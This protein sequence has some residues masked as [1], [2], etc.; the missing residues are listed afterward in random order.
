MLVLRH[1]N[2]T[3]VAVI[4]GQEG[5]GGQ[6]GILDFHGNSLRVVG[7]AVILHDLD[8]HGCEALCHSLDGAAFVDGHDIL[9]AGFKCNGRVTG[10]VGIQC[11]AKLY[12]FGRIQGQVVVALKETHIAGVADLLL[13]AVDDVVGLQGL[14]AIQ[15]K[16]ICDGLVVAHVTLVAFLQD[17]NLEGLAV[18][19]FGV[20]DLD[21]RIAGCAGNQ[22]VVDHAHH[23]GTGGSELQQ[24]CP[25]GFGVDQ[26]TQAEYLVGAHGQALFQTVIDEG[27]D[28][29]GQVD[30]VG[31]VVQCVVI[32]RQNEGVLVDC[33]FL[34]LVDVIGQF[35]G[36][37]GGGVF[38]GVDG[39]QILIH[40]DHFH[41]G[42]IVFVHTV[43]DV[44][45]LRSHGIVVIVD[46]DLGI[47]AVFLQA[48]VVLVVELRIGNRRCLKVDGQ[49]ELEGI[50]QVLF[51]TAVA[52]VKIAGH[53]NGVAGIVLQIKLSGIKLH[54]HIGRID[55]GAAVAVGLANIG[56]LL[57]INH[58]TGGIVGDG[59][60][61]PLGIAEQACPDKT[62]GVDGTNL[63]GQRDVIT[64][65]GNGHVTGILNEV[66]R[67]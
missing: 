8:G 58:F 25:F 61:H 54:F 28:V 42:L 57:F 52:A 26:R 1:H 51:Q 33:L 19:G 22:L 21:H 64:V 36:H 40:T 35:V 43:D 17:G 3:A 11:I 18:T 45:Q 5:T 9:V 14:V 10:E 62:Q 34:D 37:I 59:G 47:Q 60:L 4:V 67:T 7:G 32:N 65:G 20:A 56:A 46:A 41:G 2:G 66:V 30:L 15:R 38:L 23:T 13:I 24:F 31:C 55:G 27:G 50:A 29:V 12:A 16:H 53:V 39:S 6:V 63:V 44:T 49:G 48:F